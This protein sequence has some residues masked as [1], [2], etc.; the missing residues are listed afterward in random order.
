MPLIPQTKKHPLNSEQTAIHTKL[1]LGPD[2]LD[3]EIQYKI[4]L[5]M[6]LEK[7]PPGLLCCR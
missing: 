6:E 7:F 3:V 2:R 5:A 1:L 4:I